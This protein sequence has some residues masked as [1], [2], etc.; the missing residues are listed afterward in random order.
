VAGYA[1]EGATFTEMH[2]SL[3]RASAIDQEVARERGYRTEFVKARLREKGFSA[4]QSRQG[5]LI[6]LFNAR[7]ECVGY[8]IRPDQPR[9]KDGKPIKY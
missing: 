9:I 2:L 1:K 4:I 3:L 5:L 7:S 6:P 8:Q